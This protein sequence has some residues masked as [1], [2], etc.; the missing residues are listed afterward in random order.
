MPTLRK[1]TSQISA[2][3]LSLALSGVFGF[4]TFLT[5]HVTPNVVAIVGSPSPRLPPAQALILGAYLAGK[6]SELHTSASNDNTLIPFTVAQG[7][8]A[9]KVAANLSELGLI[10]EPD[11]LRDYMRYKG[12]DVLIEA[13]YF[14][15]DATHTIP[16]FAHAL[17]KS[18]PTQIQVKLWPGWRIEQTAAALSQ[19]TYLDV[20]ESEFIKLARPENI[21]PDTYSFLGQ[22]PPEATL[23]GLLRPDTY[24][25]QPRA[26]TAEVLHQLLAAADSELVHIRAEADG[27]QLS[28]YDVLTLAS[29]VERETIHDDEA[30]LIAGVFMN[31]LASGM[32][33]AADPTTQYGIAHSTDWWPSLTFDPRQVIHPYNTYTNL[34][35][36]PGP[37][38]SPG[39]ASIQ[40]V[41]H[42]EETG[43]LYFRA[44]C[45]Q[46]HRHTFAYTYEQHLANSCD[47]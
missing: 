9:G 1:A 4:G 24:I 6:T 32:L 30:P 3:W 42:P 45:D 25:F 39:A 38:C 21:V 15:L 5:Y 13:G 23:E 40:G 44:A 14:E 46:S 27:H 12:L 28:W 16:E 43:Y 34:G 2:F 10:P 20:D 19:R 17:T 7:E 36:P 33:L 31:R 35:L 8:S 26:T 47:T 11:L 18:I 29:I 22:L 37:I 41:L